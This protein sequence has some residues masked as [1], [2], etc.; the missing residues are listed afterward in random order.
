MTIFD[1]ILNILLPDYLMHAIFKFA[2]KS[3]Y[4]K[5]LFYLLLACII[6]YGIAHSITIV[7]LAVFVILSFS[8]FLVKL[9]WAIC[10]LIFLF[11][12]HYIF[13][14][15][16][17]SV[18]TDLWREV[19]LLCISGS[20]FLQICLGKL[21][22]PAKNSL[23]PIIITYI[24]WGII[25]ILNS[26]SLLA[27]LA[28]FRFM[29]AFVPLYFVALSTI[30]GE[31]QVKRYI[32]A[33][34]IS[35]FIVSCYAI[36]Q[37][38]FVSLMGIV[39]PG[40]AID[41][42]RRNVDTFSFREGFYRATSVLLSANEL[43]NFLSVCILFLFVFNYY[44]PQYKSEHHKKLVFSMIIMFI[45]LLFSM[46]RTALIA[47]FSAILVISF[48]KRRPKPILIACIAVIALSLVLPYSINLLFK[49]IYTFTDRYFTH[50]IQNQDL[51][52]RF[53]QSPLLGH[54]FSLTKSAAEKLNMDRLG[55]TPVGSADT[56]FFMRSL[57]IGLVGFLLHFSI[58]LLFLRNAYRGT[59]N[60]NL[61]ETYRTISLAIFGVLIYLMLTSV[62]TSPLESVSISG[63]YWVI[64]AIAVSIKS[65][66]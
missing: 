18:A 10:L 33:I 58:W 8:F 32:N 16:Y 9:D 17:P 47:L 43:G 13:K 60:V 28:G 31:R 59:K 2:N 26:F 66:I 4:L 23:N 24:I 19:F 6:G 30:K 50:T 65:K 5:A 38:V 27:G 45:A 46:A 15:L 36:L 53:W 21:H 7:A 12:F 56:D 11:P 20:W 25:E 40:T 41:F 34:L 22:L 62:H 44:S 57:Q 55:V 1:N 37:F 51:W 35:G 49:P 3:R 54:G 63:T 29:F 48:L 61:S 39:D 52:E 42:A 14:G 64:G